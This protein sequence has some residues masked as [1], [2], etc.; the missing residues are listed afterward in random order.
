MLVQ[1]GVK[2]AAQLGLDI[3]VIA[4]GSSSLELFKKAGFELLEK[5]SQD[6][7]PYGEESVYE[8]FYLIKRAPKEAEAAK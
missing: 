2:A 7:S 3:I 4:M 8:T 6:L 1:S 5:E